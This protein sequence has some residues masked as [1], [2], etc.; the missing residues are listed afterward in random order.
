M[1]VARGLDMKAI[2]QTGYGAPARVL[3]LAEVEKPAVEAEKVLVKVHATSIN[4]GD[5]RQVIAD[6]VIVRFMG[7]LRRPRDPKVGGDV[8]G[9]VEAVGA[10]VTHVK[11][12]DEVFGVRTGAFAEYVSGKYMVAKPAG[13]SFEQA[14]AIPVAGTTALQAIRDKGA[15]RAGQIV[16]VNG[17]GGGVGHF[18]VQIA[19]AL[20]AEVTATT[21]T[22]KLELVRA[23]GA[24]HVIDYRREDFTNRRQRYDVIID[25]A[26]NK[27][28]RATRRTLKPEGVLVIVGAHR[29]VIRRLVSG[30]LRHR[31]L[32][33]RI[34]FFLAQI[35]MDDLLTLKEMAESGQIRP[36]IDRTYA[37]DDAIEAIE[38]AARQTVGGKVVLTVAP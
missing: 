8:A 15:V 32:R 19:K 4:S 37:L 6:P 24:D 13:L 28:F 14:A 9:V 36:V 21:S 22:D 5:C 25:I 20:G 26:G 11:P 18:A 38:Y 7:G 30:T 31:L 35:T 2:L 16:L 29:G 3:T 33:Q 12:G 17:A 23:L 34:V 10:G 27:S 1:A